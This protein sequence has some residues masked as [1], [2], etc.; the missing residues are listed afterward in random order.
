MK[1]TKRQKK[2]TE[3]RWWFIDDGD[4]NK[5]N[6]IA[7]S[8]PINALSTFSNLVRARSAEPLHVVIVK[9]VAVESDKWPINPS[10]VARH[11]KQNIYKFCEMRDGEMCTALAAMWRLGQSPIE[12]N[13]SLRTYSQRKTIIT[14]II[15]NCGTRFAA[16][17]LLIFTPRCWD[18]YE[19]R[20]HE[21]I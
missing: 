5:R 3:R 1:K 4:D 6:W 14:I 12:R 18:D 11:N 20:S 19:N 17:S 21:T 7:R 13:A 15:F 10:V 8:D 9:L 2:K 16:F